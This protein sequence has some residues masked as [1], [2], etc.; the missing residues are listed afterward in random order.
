MQDKPL[1]FLKSQND[2]LE[3]HKPA[4]CCISVSSACPLKCKM[5][6]L[7]KNGYSKSTQEPTLD[8]W[9]GFIEQA[10]ELSDHFLEIG[11]AGG[12]PLLDERNLALIK[13]SSAKGLVTSMPT[14]GFLIDREMALKIA[15]SGLSAIGISL[16]GIHRSTHDFLRGVEGCYDRVMQAISCLG[17]THNSPKIGILTAISGKNIDE[18]VELAKWVNVDSRIQTIVFQAIIQPF[19]TPPD[20][21]WYNR[22]EYSFL[23]PQDIQ[24]VRCA[25]DEL[26]GLKQA[27]Y[28][29]SNSVA[30]LESF[31]RYFADPGAFVK[32]AACN[33]DFY[34]H[35]D[36][37]GNL[38]ICPQKKSIGNIKKD[39]LR[40]LW[41]CA[42]ANQIR[43][44]IRGCGLNCHHLLNV[45]YQEG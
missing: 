30:Q 1:D 39:N 12:E 27:G 31:K 3:I 6:S 16:D 45:L 37:L 2:L 28:K 38:Y 18:V 20:S 29:L 5:C 10:A 14:N 25:L 7:W 4:F 44:E 9:S 24:K 13:V 23:W 8:E 11:F 17:K 40:D 42:A 21:R 26:I 32:N 35:A 22:S 43:E 34:M 19:N 41:Y 33:A 15:D 36:Q